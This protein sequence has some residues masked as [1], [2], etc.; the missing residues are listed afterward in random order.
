MS[1]LKVCSGCYQEKNINEF[2]SSS[3]NIIRTTCSRCRKNASLPSHLP[4]IM[5]VYLLEINEMNETSEFLENESARLVIGEILNLE[6][7]IEELPVTLTDEERDKEIATKIIS[8][9]S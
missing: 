4:D 9:A 5:Y 2:S 8:L 7:L 1:N 3:K 6:P